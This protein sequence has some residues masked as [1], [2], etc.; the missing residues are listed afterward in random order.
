M[1]GST[2]QQDTFREFLASFYYGS[3]TDLNFKF[4]AQLSDEEAAEFFQKFLS[5]VVDAID[6]QRL[7]YITG[8]VH[9][10]QSLVYGQSSRWEYTDEPFT[11]LTKELNSSRVALVTSSGHF[12]ADQ[13]PENFPSAAMTQEEV[14]NEIKTFLKSPPVMSPI[15]KLTPPNRLRVRHAGYDIRGAEKDHNVVF[16][17][18]RL[19]ELEQEK[20][21][22][23]VAEEAWSF[24]G[25]CAQTPLLKTVGP[26]LADTIRKKQIDAVIL[27]PV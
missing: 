15:P 13:E 5:T 9:E 1:S 24:M 19:L 8:L 7:S 25:A 26:E 21:I 27:V 4:L 10:W 12:V 2:K 6:D 17:L 16:P 22:G 23:E 14:V 3:R 20:I 11:P 18:Q